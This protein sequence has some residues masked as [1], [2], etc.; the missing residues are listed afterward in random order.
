MISFLVLLLGTSLS[1][2]QDMRYPPG[3][4][5]GGYGRNDRDVLTATQRFIAELD[6]CGQADYPL[7]VAANRFYEETRMGSATSG[8]AYREL[9]RA[10]FARQ[11]PDNVLDSW[12]LVVVAR[13]RRNIQVNPPYDRP[14]YPPTYP[15]QR[16]VYFQGSFET[17]PVSLYAENAE[18]IR[19]ECLAYVDRVRPSSVDDID[20]FGTRYRNGPAY[21]NRDQLCSL[22]AAN[23]RSLTP[24]QG[25]I[26]V[27]GTIEST[28]FYFEG[29]PMEVLSA[30]RTLVPGL[31][32]RDQID[33]VTVN[34]QRYH[35]GP[36]YWR[37]EEV[38][39]LIE[40]GIG[41]VQYPQYY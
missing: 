21:W 25:T 38:A 32:G 37:P 26:T 12:D 7:R 23:A 13:S 16:G 20:I 40:Q 9:R 14:T 19:R 30:I 4:G 28:P 11:L 31:V 15:P 34:G 10:L 24:R 41:P 8:T 22:A 6:H 3:H 27:Q 29:A 36:S 33:D 17:T 39:A 1:S 18:G 2:A 5:Q 35:N